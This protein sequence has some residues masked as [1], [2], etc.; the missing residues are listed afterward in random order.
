[1]PALVEVA[2]D[3]FFG[4]LAGTS[5]AALWSTN[6]AYHDEWVDLRMNVG[7]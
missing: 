2:K 1:M 3:F 6:F 4:T 7:C 5:V